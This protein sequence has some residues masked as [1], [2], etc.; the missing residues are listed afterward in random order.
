MNLTKLS[1]FSLIELIVTLSVAAIILTIGIPGFQ[2]IVKNNILTTELNRLVTDLH[3]ARME[4]IKRNEDVTICKKNTTATNCNNTGSWVMG[5]IVFVDPNR[6]GVVDTGEE[7]IRVNPDLETGLTLDYSKNRITYTSQG[8]A[9][10]Y[11]GS[12][13]ISDSRG[14]SYAKKRVVSNTGRIRTG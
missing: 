3:L 6:N 2:S 9:Y 10:G 7:I 14:S 5:W 11:A 12:F 13:V 1:G 4:A 8:F